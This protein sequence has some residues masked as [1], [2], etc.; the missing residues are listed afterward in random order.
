MRNGKNYIIPS[1]ERLLS[2][3]P[4]THNVTIVLLPNVEGEC[5]DPGLVGGIINLRVSCPSVLIL[6]MPTS[7]IRLTMLYV[8]SRVAAATN[9]AHVLPYITNPMG[10]IR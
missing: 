1:P 3:V 10:M 7:Q 8:C 9:D 2:L 5:G 6:A 4:I